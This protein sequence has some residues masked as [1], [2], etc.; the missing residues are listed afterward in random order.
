MQEGKILFS[1]NQFI[2]VFCELYVG[3]F[4]FH[5][6]FSLILKLQTFFGYG[7]CYNE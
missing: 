4:L 2:S 5:L 3:A 6:F 1:Q 7:E